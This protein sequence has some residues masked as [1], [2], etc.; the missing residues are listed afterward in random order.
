MQE[1][2]WRNAPMLR[3][4]SGSCIE[5][6]SISVHFL[7]MRLCLPQLGHRAST[8][9]LQWLGAESNPCITVRPW[10][11]D[12]PPVSKHQLRVLCALSETK[13]ACCSTVSVCVPAHVTDENANPPMVDVYASIV[14]MPISS[15]PDAH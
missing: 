3:G 9:V 7:L 6:N 1:D 8:F 11:A 10:I 2:G 13:D 4:A 12:L 14:V 15:E 5:N